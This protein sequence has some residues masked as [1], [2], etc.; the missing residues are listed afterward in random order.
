[1]S[2]VPF[3]QQPPI[4]RLLRANEVGGRFTSVVDAQLEYNRWN[5]EVVEV[6]DQLVTIPTTGW[7]LN[8]SDNLIDADG[9]DTGSPVSGSGIKYVYL[10]NALASYLP[11]SLALS[12]QAP[13]D[14][15]TSGQ[16]YLGTSGNAANWRLIAVVYMVDDGIGNYV[17]RDSETQRLVSHVENRIPRSLRGLPGY[18]NDNAQ[19]AVVVANAAFAALSAASP[20]PGRV[21]FV[22]GY[23]PATAVLL[24][25]DV[26]VVA[27]T[28]G[29]VSQWGIGVDSTT[30]PAVAAQ[31][32][33]AAANVAASCSYAFEPLTGYHYALPLAQTGAG[34]TFAADTGRHGAAADV[35]A[36][37]LSGVVLA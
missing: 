14:S 20:P 11:E 21:E 23:G 37:V 9:L 34:A 13:N 7:Q 15:V 16:P 19:T 22:Q 28:A 27:G 3:I 33:A 6:N 17:F 4:A 26:A 32:A 5:G 10:S 35:P 30:D 8:N 24:S 25:L 31:V 18:V 29:A 12:E 1:M 36:T 2:L